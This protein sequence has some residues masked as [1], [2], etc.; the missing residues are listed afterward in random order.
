MANRLGPTW[1]NRITQ[2]TGPTSTGRLSKFALLV[3]QIN[4]L[5]PTFEAFTE[6][7]LVAR[8]HELRLRP[9]RATR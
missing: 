1:L 7:E 6:A 8:S 3:E 9:A 5:E 4:E 2:L